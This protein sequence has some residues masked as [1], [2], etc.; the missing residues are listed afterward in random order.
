MLGESGKDLPRQNSGEFKQGS[1]G[2]SSV[3]DLTG[4]SFDVLVALPQFTLFGVVVPTQQTFAHHPE[5][6]SKFFESFEP[7]LF[8]GFFNH[9]VGFAV[10]IDAVA[11]H[12][13][14]TVIDR[15]NGVRI[16]ALEGHARL[17]VAVDQTAVGYA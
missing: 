7:P 10:P 9:V 4:K 6:A 17:V 12:L 13:I 2:V 3:D 14:D 8:C 5:V 15:L 1:L 16:I 11:N